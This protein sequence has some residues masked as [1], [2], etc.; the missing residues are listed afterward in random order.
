MRIRMGKM[1]VF[2]FSSGMDA[3]QLAAFAR[4]VEDLG[5]AAYWFPEARGGD[6]SFALAA[7]LLCQTTRLQVGTGIA[8]IYARD[9]VTARLGLH[10]LSRLSGNRFILGLGVAHPDNVEKTR[11]HAFGKPVPT[12]RAYLDLMDSVLGNA[13]HVEGRPP[14]VLAALGPLMTKLAVQR[15][16][17]VLPYNVTPE[18]TAWA[19]EHMGAEPWLGIE[20][21]V[22]LVQDTAQA[23]DVARN[24][25]APY[26]S[27]D[28]YRNA[29]RRLGFSDEELANGGSDRFVDAMVAWGDV[30]SIRQR[31]Q[32]HFDAGADHVCIQPLH[33]QGKPM[34]DERVVEALA[35]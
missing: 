29:W 14:I 21:K 25:L 20:Q 9:G 11:G 15:T 13:P 35:P 7:Y 4:K 8:N 31:V 2:C 19:R 32:A 16:D 33:P 12:M 34:P 28:H 18:H 10:P 6:E 23:R 22:L 5:Y 26:L 30:E 24:S 17:G 27:M 1:G 3:A